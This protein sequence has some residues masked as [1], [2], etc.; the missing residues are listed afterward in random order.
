M[1]SKRAAKTPTA[2][3]VKPAPV[4]K[5]SKRENDAAL[6]KATADQPELIDNSNPEDIGANADAGRNDGVNED[7]NPDLAQH[8]DNAAVEVAKR[9]ADNVEP[10]EGSTGPDEP[11]PDATVIHRKVFVLVDQHVDFRV[12]DHDANIRA[13]RQEMLNSG[14][15]PVGD[16]EYIGLSPHGDGE[17]VDVIYEG[18][19]VPTYVAS[20]PDVAHPRV[21]QNQPLATPAGVAEADAS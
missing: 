9:S 16:V 11:E 5:T 6:K 19:A 17:S 20:D 12:Y 1:A 7:T 4:R 2:K 13:T 18:K 3:G 21:D 10:V 14:L 15:R 8:P